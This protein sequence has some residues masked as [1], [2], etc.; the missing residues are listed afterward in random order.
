MS[1]DYIRG[2]R[3]R[4]KAETALQAAISSG[5]PARELIRCA[6]PMLSLHQLHT[7]K[8]L[9]ERII[10]TKIWEEHT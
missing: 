7:I 3:K 8:K 1:N 10:T 4:Y 9:L 2:Q 5:C 6:L